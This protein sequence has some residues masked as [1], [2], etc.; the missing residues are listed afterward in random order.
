MRLLRLAFLAATLSTV[1]IAD[2]AVAQVTAP[3][4]RDTTVKLPPGYVKEFGTMWT[5][6]APPFDYWKARYGFTPTKAWLD[7]VR[8]ASI[9]LPNCSSSFVSSRGLVMTNHHCARECITAV[10]TP[11]SNF[12]ELGFVAPTQAEERKCPGLYVDQLQS[13]EDVTDRIQ[14][15]VT[16][17][18]SA[19]QVTQR[20]SA[21]AEI[22]KACGAE[23]GLTCQVVS[24]YQG[25]A[26]SL[27]R[28]KRFDDLRLVMA[29]EEAISFFGGDPD[30]FTF[31]R[32][33]L[34]LSL[35]RVY[36]N[37]QPY[38]PRD[39]L[40]W[41]KNGAKEGDLVFVTG[42]PGSTG[43]LLTVAQMEYL[44]DVQY[45]LQ[46]ASYDRTLAILRQLA[47]RDEE[48]RRRVENDIFSLENS[49]K[50]VIGYLS[51]LQDSSL[52][53]KKRDFERDFRRR[54]AADPKLRARYGS[55]WDAIATA[56]RELT[57]MNKQLRWYNFGGSQLLN[58][59][60]GIV[61]VPLQAKLPDS[62]RLPQYR[63]DG[64]EQIRNS[65]LG[66]VSGD[67]ESDKEMLQA[68]LTAAGKDLPKNDPYLQ[69]I[70]RGQSP[71][72]A[73]EAAVN[74]TQLADS[75][76]RASLLESGSAA[77]AASK[78]P[79]IVLA[80]K[81]EP[82]SRRTQQRAAR[83]QDVISANAEK[84]GQA[85]FAAYGRSLPPDATF[86]LRISDGVVKSFPMNGTIAPYKTSFYGLYGR[87]A[88]FDDKPPFQLPE[89][90]KS[91]R[92]RL[93]L[94]Q[95]LDFVTTND[96]IGGNSG[97]P[98]INQNA[99]VVGL[100]FDG[101]IDQLPNRFLYTDDVARAVA[102]H[103]RGLTEALRKVY[104]ADRIADELEGVQ[105]QVR[106]VPLQ[107][108]SLRRAPAP[109]RDSTGTGQR[110]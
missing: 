52:M 71:E 14:N 25:G 105:A 74:G 15:A 29:P 36:E 90:W 13:I 57:A 40:K 73:A 85:I 58:A 8:Q 21:I 93:D 41:S 28:F 108:D 63:G 64:L 23:K 76:T 56:E 106:R 68:W 49:K 67:A 54:I 27:Y 81:L 6:E 33:D 38:Q 107:G 87:S 39:Y 69:T 4:P 20:N 37:N 53:A 66:D 104:E 42:N 44:R 50:A 60:G 12:Q 101:N 62:L 70:L 110:R 35:M 95:P 59:A 72:V 92:A 83:L 65:I 30:N 91:H 103:S 51:G 86:S 109:V 84:V 34:D 80:R 19:Q 75:A 9:R 61:R 79:L 88:E 18:A 43:R 55:A 47:A 32:Y 10:S 98:V 48:T 11:D 31:P 97:S 82:I 100:I 77:V 78:D 45:P 2:Q 89:R 22:E 96:I 17:R 5:F 46:L 1:P 16:A 102:V 24:Y 3:A 26:Y 99:E 7:H 94:S